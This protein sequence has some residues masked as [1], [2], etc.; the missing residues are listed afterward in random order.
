[1]EAIVLAGG[2]G[3]RLREAVTTVPKPMAPVNDQPFLNYVLNFLRE[4]GVAHAV[5]ATGYLHDLIERHFGREFNGLALSYSVEKEPL[6]TG[7]ALKQALAQTRDERVLVMNGDTFFN[8]T[9]SALLNVHTRHQADLTLALKA[10]KDA[11]RY[12]LVHLEGARVVRFE[13][14]QAHQSGYINGGVYLINRDLFEPYSLPEKFSFETDFLKPY[15]EKLKIYGAVFDAF[16]IDIG[17]PAD[18]RR[19]QAELRTHE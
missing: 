4:N 10:M 17:V 5:L 16:F 1:M 15:V 11:S 6:G 8:I 18:Y 2:F 12:G 9:V 19:A 13:E 7:G 14:K 3:T